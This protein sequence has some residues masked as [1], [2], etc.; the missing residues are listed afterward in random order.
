LW[1]IQGE[2]EENASDSI[3]IQ[4]EVEKKFFSDSEIS[5][6]EDRM[7]RIRFQE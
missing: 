5:S 4:E 1:T 6:D 3:Q 7:K 2:G